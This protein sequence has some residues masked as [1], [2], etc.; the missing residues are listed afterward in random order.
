MVA[1]N[2]NIGIHTAGRGALYHGPGL[3]RLGKR[4]QHILGFTRQIHFRKITFWAKHVRA[5]S[6]DAATALSW[7]LGA[8]RRHALGGVHAEARLLILEALRG[9]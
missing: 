8:L 4:M 1:S 7:V 9:G 6:A 5:C 3:T 2:S